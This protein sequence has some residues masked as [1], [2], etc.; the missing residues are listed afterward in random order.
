LPLVDPTLK[1]A[2]TPPAFDKSKLH[3]EALVDRIHAAL[4]KALVVIAA[5]A[6]YGKTT[7]LADF[8]AHSDLRV[9]WVRASESP[10]DAILLARLIVASLRRAF[11]RARASADPRFSLPSPPESAARVLSAWIED[12]IPDSFVLVID[13]VHQLGNESGAVEFLDE[14]VRIRPSSM[15]LVLSGRE[16]PELSLAR[17]LAEGNLEGFGPQDLSFSRNEVA[18]VSGLVGGSELD[19]LE[20]GR[21]HEVTRGWATGVVLSGVVAKGVLRGIAPESSPLVYD[22]LS[23]VVLNRLPDDL[24]RFALDISVLA[25]MTPDL[26]DALLHRDDGSR[27]LRRLVRKGIFLDA[28]E[29]ESPSYSFHGLFRSFLEDTLAATDPVRQARLRV[30]ASGLLDRQGSIEAAFRLLSDAGEMERASRLAEA[31]AREVGIEGRVELLQAWWNEL[32]GLDVRVPEI[33]LALATAYMDRGD[34]ELAEELASR[35]EP[36]RDRELPLQYTLRLANLRAAILF[37]RGRYDECVSLAESVIGS[38]GVG[39]RPMTLA[40]ALE[41]K[42]RGLAAMKIRLEE[43]RRDAEAAVDLMSRAEDRHS[44]ARALTN[45]AVVFEALGHYR[46]VG[47]I[48]ER[49]GSL[50]KDH[51]SPVENAYALSNLGQVRHKE[52]DLDSAL[53]MYSDALRNARQAAHSYL[54]ALVLFE[55]GDVFNDV[56]MAMQAAQLYGEGLGIAARIG[57]RYL[58]EYGCLRT[59]VLYR[60]RGNLVV[61]N[62]WMQRAL[63]QEESGTRTA[64]TSI[65]LAALES[66][67]APMNALATLKRV[68]HER[69]KALSADEDVLA[70]VFM[71]SAYTALGN[72]KLRDEAIDAALTMAGAKGAEQQIAAELMANEDLLRVFG[73]RSSGAAVFEVVSG[74]IEVMK[75]FRRLHLADTEHP[76]DASVLRISALGRGHIHFKGKPLKGLKRQVKEVLLYLVDRKEA[77]KEQLTEVFWATYPPGRRAANLHT[78]IHSIRASLGKTSVLFEE[79]VYYLNPLIEMLYD[80]DQFAKAAE[81]ADRLSAGDPRRYFALT[82]AISLY[83]GQFLSESVSHWCAERRRN[84]ELRYLDLVAALALEALTRDQPQRALDHLRRGLAID[85]LRDDLNLRYLQALGRLGQVSEVSLHYQQ[86]TLLVRQELGIDPPEEIRALYSRLIG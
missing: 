35:M 85:P 22:Y 59:S 46:T 50:L 49:V 42:A 25:V 60:R 53:M 33:I 83:S 41:T 11:H 64:T 26:C 54:E 4:D 43:A 9:C 72:P 77:S 47:T 16:V 51:G 10:L 8:T 76:R 84:L 52:G 30:R 31:H 62:E 23:S 40:I 78:A 79:G 75:S 68:I 73:S 2:I 36:Y 74:R 19:P 32:S 67:A 55:Q 27:M 1:H 44:Q 37:Q 7:L 86:Y 58:L 14:L 29:G 61:S 66:P 34:V 6:G 5:P 81:V 69:K 38:R 20:V 17:L 63:Q 24:R 48:I 57:N 65:Q 21:I 18:S 15:S 3:R 13:D 56:G 82:E 80:V 45:L 12:T 39:S 28:T 71:A 70:R